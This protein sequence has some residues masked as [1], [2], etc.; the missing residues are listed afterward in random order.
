[1]AVSKKPKTPKG[2]FAWITYYNSKKELKFILTSK[3]DRNMYY[4]YELIN[5]E[6]QK[7]GKDKDPIE[8]EEKL[9]IHE[10][11]SK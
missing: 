6:F 8:L 3:A 7:I 10:R 11:M 1:M 4:I 5:G 9:K 2:E